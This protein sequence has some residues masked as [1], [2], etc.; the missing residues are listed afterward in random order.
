[1][2]QRNRGARRVGFA[3]ISFSHH[4]NDKTE[5]NEESINLNSNGVEEV[6]LK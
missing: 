5:V 6:K 2:L 1:M 3:L 4:K